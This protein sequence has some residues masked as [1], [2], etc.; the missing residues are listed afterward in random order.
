MMVRS[1]EAPGGGGKEAALEGSVALI[2]LLAHACK[3]GSLCPRGY[4]GWRGKKSL[5]VV[6]YGFRGRGLTV[7]T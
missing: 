1:A 7:W 5:G 2:T 3:A 4:G 6:N